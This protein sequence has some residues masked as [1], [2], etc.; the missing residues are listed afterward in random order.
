MGSG[1]TTAPWLCDKCQMIGSEA[2]AYRH[3]TLT[4]HRVRALTANERRAF[5][6]RGEWELGEV[7]A[8]MADFTRIMEL[9]EE[10]DA[11]AQRWNMD[12]P[13]VLQAMENALP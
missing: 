13:S 3:A 8:R 1:H 5:A 11:L 9:F 7:E 4:G 2:A 10:A 12:L 6:P